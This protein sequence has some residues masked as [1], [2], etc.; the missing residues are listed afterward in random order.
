MNIPIYMA[1]PI[2]RVTDNAD[3]TTHIVG[4]NKHDRLYLD[5]DGCIQYINIQCMAGTASGEY[6]FSVSDDG[7]NPVSNRYSEGECSPEQTDAEIYEL[8]TVRWVMQT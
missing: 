6:F 7:R 8:P 1:M 4:T 5:E 3:G 2:I